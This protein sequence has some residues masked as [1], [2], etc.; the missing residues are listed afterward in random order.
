MIVTDTSQ[1]QLEFVPRLPN[2]QYKC[3]SPTTSAEKLEK[4]IPKRA[5]VDLVTIGQAIHWS[6]RPNF[7][8][9]VQSD[10]KATGSYSSMVLHYPTGEC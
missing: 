10:L 4:D 7:Y 6:D 9:Q 3:T 5:T 1:K 2:V 8:Q